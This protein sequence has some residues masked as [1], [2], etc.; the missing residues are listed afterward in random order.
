M[1]PCRH[2]GKPIGDKPPHYSWA[3]WAKRE[4]CSKKCAARSRPWTHKGEAHWHWRGGRTQTGHG[5][6]QAHAPD[7]P[8]ANDKGYVMEHRLVMERVLGRR[9][10][11]SEHV[12]HKNGVRDDNRPENLEVIDGREHNRRHSL[13]TGF[14][15]HPYKNNRRDPLTGRYIRKPA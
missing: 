3:Q 2:C 11:R 10:L 6:V 12:H 9:I 5:Y 1:K 15:H 7:H 8:E 14:G 4:T 13:L